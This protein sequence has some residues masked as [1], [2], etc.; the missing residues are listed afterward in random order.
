[1]RARPR[2]CGSSL[3]FEYLRNVDYLIGQVASADFSQVIEQQKNVTHRPLTKV[4]RE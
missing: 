4:N 2:N 3:I 1:M